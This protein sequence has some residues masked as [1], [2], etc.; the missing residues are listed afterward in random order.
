L[1]G[2][3]ISLFTV[4]QSQS[5]FSCNIADTP[6]YRYRQAAK[7]DLGFD[8]DG[9]FHHYRVQD[10][11]HMKRLHA[12]KA[13][14]LSALEKRIEKTASGVVT[15]YLW[16][17]GLVVL[18]EM[19]SCTKVSSLMRTRNQNAWDNFHD[20]IS[21][22]SLETDAHSYLTDHDADASCFTPILQLGT[23]G[24]SSSTR[25]DNGILAYGWNNK[26]FNFDGRAGGWANK[27]YGS[28]A[29]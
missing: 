17:N 19:N 21:V 26:A 28:N 8:N 12:Q 23:H 29:L 1:E 25:I 22:K 5:I 4:C 10:S 9:S 16:K 15:D 7:E 13:D 27:C 24:G 14:G 20:D 2:R 18:S 11:D 6:W 3:G